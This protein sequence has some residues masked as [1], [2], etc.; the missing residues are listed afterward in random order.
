MDQTHIHPGGRSTSGFTSGHCNSCAVGEFGV[1]DAPD[2]EGAAEPAEA[3]EEPEMLR[4]KGAGGCLDLGGGGILV[5]IGGALGGNCWSGGGG[6][7]GADLVGMEGRRSAVSLELDLPEGL[8]G[9]GGIFPLGGGGTLAFGS[10]GGGPGF[11]TIGC[12]PGLG[13]G[14][15]APEGGGGGMT[16]L[17]DPRFCCGVWP[18]G[19]G[20]GGGDVVNEDPLPSF[21]TESIESVRCLFAGGGG[22]GVEISSGSSLLGEVREGDLRTKIASFSSTDD[23][24]ESCGGDPGGVLSSMPCW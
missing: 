13:G 4:F 11:L 7:G 16:T 18:L 12:A 9:G 22:G 19:G 1:E 3:T 15:G 24:K 6:G 20:G 8:G 2:V 23:S 21:S 17:K 14:G 5:V 10:G